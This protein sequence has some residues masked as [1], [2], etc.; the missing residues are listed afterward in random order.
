MS[1]VAHS[2][3]INYP[4]LSTTE[5]I[6]NAQQND[7]QALTTLLVRHRNFISNRFRSLAPDWAD[8]SDMI[9]EVNIRVWRFIRQLRSPEA[10]RR[11]LSRIINMVFYDELRKR[12]KNIQLQSLDQP[13]LLGDGEETNREL[14]D[15]RYTPD[16][17]LLARELYST[18]L[19]AIENVPAK[20]R[21]PE[22]LRDLEGLPYDAIAQLTRSELGTVKSRIARARLRIQKQIAAYLDECA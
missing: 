20:L 21:T 22:V 8:Q 13:V 12:P 15:R 19:D 2:K 6:I 10:F 11:W 9:Q 14:E 1:I 4:D 16:E 7:E 3:R 17:E 5:L 18:L